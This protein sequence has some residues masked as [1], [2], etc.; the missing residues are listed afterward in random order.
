MNRKRREKREVMEKARC[1]CVCE[2]VESVTVKTIA[3]RIELFSYVQGKRTT[4]C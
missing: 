1:V 2:L 3:L 4:N